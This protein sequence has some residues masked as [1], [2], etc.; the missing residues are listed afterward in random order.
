MN[1]IFRA[2]S[3]VLVFLAVSRAQPEFER[4]FTG[5]LLRIDYFHYGSKNQEEVVLDQMY[6]E[7]LW[8]GSRRS[9]I[10]TLNLGIY[11]VKVF[12]LQ[13]NQLIYS[14]GFSTLF[15]EWQTTDEAVNGGRKVI[16]ETVQIPFPRRAVQI[17]FLRRDRRNHFTRLIGSWIVK[18]DSWKIRAEKRAP[19]VTVYRI[20]E[21]GDPIEKVD[22]VIL[23]EGYTREEAEK[24]QG[25]AQKMVETLFGFEPFRS[26]REDFNVT[27]LFVPSPQSGTDD[28]AF[29][30]YRQTI[31]NSSFKTFG[32]Q[33][34]LMT[35]DNKT[36]RDIASAVPHEALI[37]LV[38]SK[39]YGGGG[40]Y[41]LY[42]ASTS[43]NKWSGYI[44]VHEFGHSFGGLG[45]EYYSSTVAYNE[46]YP[47]GVEPWEPNITAL[48]DPNHLKWEQ[49]VKIGTPIPTPWGKEEYDRRNEEYHKKY[50]ELRRK[51]ASQ[52]KI[53]KL[54]KKHRE[55]LRKFFAQNP[56]R[57]VVGAFEGAGYASRGLYRPALDCIMFSR[58]MIPFDPVCRAALERRI[59]FLIGK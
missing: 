27:A 24:F 20:I 47:Q 17:D 57:G 49:F 13:T 10:D 59:R 21:N 14:H 48:L 50:Q 45:D 44:F 26:H 35:Y 34:Y 25:D 37:I 16:H 42:A 52:S 23:A 2:L 12:D 39:A 6:K 30:V 7:P 56:Y 43:D 5:E 19:Q 38:N 28:P 22:L 53:Q 32:L 3:I 15:N 31:L 54:E 36:V 11:L 1:R 40:I 29:G 9:L 55:W 41:N 18:P 33:R 58:K 51:G 46:F 8:P 4:Y